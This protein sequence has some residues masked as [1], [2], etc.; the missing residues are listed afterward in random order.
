MCWWVCEN[1]RNVAVQCRKV[2]PKTCH[3]FCFFFI[4]FL[5]NLLASTKCTC[6]IRV[7][8]CSTF[9]QQWVD[10]LCA[11]SLWRSSLFVIWTIRFCRNAEMKIFS[12]DDRMSIAWQPRVRPGKLWCRRN[13]SLQED[14]IIYLF[15]Y[16]SCVYV[17][18][19]L[20]ANT[21][22]QRESA[23]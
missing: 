7:Y 22:A 23:Q 2:Y 13:V 3:K 5:T 20:F 11:F 6:W 9:V 12:V 8:L 19:Y 10:M 17:C 4:I 1:G 16:H 18:A 21:K 14:C 15:T